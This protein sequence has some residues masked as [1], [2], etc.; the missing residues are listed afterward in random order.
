[1]SE[2]RELT[3]GAP[4]AKPARL[5]SQ[6]GNDTNYGETLLGFLLYLFDSGNDHIYG[7]SGNDDLAVRTATTSWSTLLA[8]PP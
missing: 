4:F 2:P 3:A 5:R 7:G 8:P 6:A 1:M